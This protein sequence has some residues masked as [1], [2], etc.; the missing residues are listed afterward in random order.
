M[1]W[2]KQVQ[3]THSTDCRGDLP[4]T[5]KR[6]DGT[7]LWMLEKESMS[8]RLSSSSPPVAPVI[9][10]NHVHLSMGKLDGDLFL[11]FD[12]IQECSPYILSFSIDF[13]VILESVLNHA[14]R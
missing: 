9:G 4:A 13:C 6:N 2:C 7:L 10:I 8:D 3:H 1:N 5:V 11:L 12:V 14:C